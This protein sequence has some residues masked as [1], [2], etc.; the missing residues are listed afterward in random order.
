MSKFIRKIKKNWSQ[1]TIC[2]LAFF[3]I[4]SIFLFIPTINLIK[5]QVL[6]TLALK[7]V[8]QSA[9][10][11]TTAQATYTS[12]VVDRLESLD[13]MNITHDYHTQK[14]AVPLPFTYLKAIGHQLIEDEEDLQ[15]RIYSDYPF[16]WRAEEES[17]LDQF[18]KEALA[19]L[20]AHPDSE[21]YRY[22]QQDDT[23]ILR[24]TMP[25]I[26]KPS[27]VD[28]HNHYPGSPKTDWK[29]GD[30]RGI[31]ELKQRIRDYNLPVYKTLKVVIMLLSLMAITGGI[32]LVMSLRS[33]QQYSRQLEQNL[34][35]R[36]QAM[37]EAFTSIHNGPLQTLGLMLRQI[38]E[39]SFNQ[40]FF[41]ER[42][43]SLNKEIR[44]IGKHLTEEAHKD[45]PISI[46][47]KAIETKTTM[48]LGEGTTLDLSLPLHELFY[49]TYTLTL[50]R[51]FPYFA[52]L[53][54]KVCDFEPD[55]SIQSIEVKEK[56]CRWLEEALCNVGKHA[57]GVKRLTT[58]GK[59]KE[60]YYILRVEDNGCGLKS[61]AGNQGT[62]DS[63]KLAKQLKGEFKR[64]SLPKKGTLC[65]LSWPTFSN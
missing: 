26:L 6:D 4:I 58:I 42:L 31:L 34:V 16:P 46:T 3:F 47:R 24:Y 43:K 37:D 10:V 8:V 13:S 44:A 60:G 22:E 39:P 54:I 2:L 59:K 49:E 51:D 48:M 15:M 32:G 17:I 45:N 38:Q 29:A 30:V 53:K 9:R 57:E 35:I 52:G 18:E 63:Y 23:R 40:N 64:E 20:K 14:E 21:F 33:S 65:E 28:C 7:Y 62:K 5:R 41:Y 27:C 25:S 36:Q 12:E 61:D 19:Y 1:Y 11:L 55:D 50:K 56:L